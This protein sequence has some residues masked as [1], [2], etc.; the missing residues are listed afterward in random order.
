MSGILSTLIVAGGGP[1]QPKNVT[2][3]AYTTTG[4]TLSWDN[5]PAITTY[6]VHYGPTKT[7]FSGLTI[8]LTGS[9]RSAVINNSSFTA[10]TSYDYFVKAANISG[11][12]FSKVLSVFTNAAAPV[13]LTAV[14]GTWA[15][16]Q[17]KLTWTNVAGLTYTVWNNSTQI[18]S[19]T[20]SPT[21]TISTIDPTNTIISNLTP[22]TSYSF[23]VKTSNSTGV[24]ISSAVLSVNTP[25]AHTVTIYE[26][27]QNRFKVSCPPNSG[28]SYT[29]WRDTTQLVSWNNTGSTYVYQVSS[30][31][32]N[33]SYTI[34]IKSTNA[35]GVST[36]S[37]IKKTAP[38]IPSMNYAVLASSTT[39]WVYLT[40]A[41]S[42]ST[43][44]TVISK[45]Y[46]AYGSYLTDTQTVNT[47]AASFNISVPW[48]AYVDITY[49][50]TVK[51][52]NGELSDE[53]SVAQASWIDGFVRAGLTAMYYAWD[54]SRIAGY[55]PGGTVVYFGVS[56]APIVR[57]M[58]L[59]GTFG[60]GDSSGC[61]YFSR[62]S[63]TE[64][65]QRIYNYALIYGRGGSG[66]SGTLSTN[67]GVGTDG[68]PA[69]VINADSA[70][71][72]YFYNGNVIA[73]GG[74]GGAGGGGW[75]G[76]GGGGGGGASYSPSST[77]GGGY[78]GGSGPYSY[79]GNY[80]GST[81][82]LRG[83]PGNSYLGWNGSSYV[84][85][86]QPRYGGPGGFGGT[87]AC[88]NGGQTTS[89]TGGGGGGNAGVGSAGSG[90]SA[91]SLVGSGMP[92]AG[93]G[94]GGAPG[95]SGGFGGVQYYGWN[96]QSYTAGGA[97]GHAIKNFSR[98]TTW[99]NGGSTHG[100][101][102]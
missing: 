8:S 13:G 78:G 82:G 48:G 94:G 30:L 51:S 102:S 15:E 23:Y 44:Y 54:Y 1:A 18:T 67:G 43:S 26:V 70:P 68:S 12:V 80:E 45:Y 75:H 98:I 28:Y 89:A 90:G 42:G 101:L 55:L 34:Y 22:S 9:T 10:N 53:S 38:D 16:T 37:A 87:G 21:G 17:F 39:L 46:Y 85:P 50:I 96:Y 56:P 71:I 74:G 36:S 32:P 57:T 91:G 92:G 29:L 66:G 6:T 20:P 73:G 59:T 100:P 2:A 31:S 52:N 25:I 61:L 77:Y 41:P 79:G 99:S 49:A 64:P 81:E 93:G 14:N 69:V 47:T 86:A 3:S 7:V 62:G 24:V 76:G 4:F 19:S 35:F 72:E 60:G 97:A 65:R 84:W 11:T 63:T 58:S 27:A 95:G 40:G 88:K 5:D 83:G 33:T